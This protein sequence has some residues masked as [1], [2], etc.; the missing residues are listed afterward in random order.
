MLHLPR[1]RLRRPACHRTQGA[2]LTPTR[3]VFVSQREKDHLQR[4]PQKNALFL[5]LKRA[6]TTCSSRSR[7]IGRTI[8]NEGVAK[9][10]LGG[11]LKTNSGFPSFSP[12]CNSCMCF[13]TSFPGPL[14][15]P[16]SDFGLEPGS[17]SVAESGI[18]FQKEVCSIFQEEECIFKKI[19]K[20]QVPAPVS[21]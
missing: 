1:S 7:G 11:I 21:L 17:L 13:P 9:A 14:C 16:R 10:N 6:C 15:H 19:S 12:L 2:I 3:F 20:V 4:S 8:Q 5:G 18:H